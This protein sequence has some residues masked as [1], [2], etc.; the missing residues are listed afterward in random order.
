[1]INPLRTGLENTRVWVY[2]ARI[3][4]SPKS[5]LNGLT[6]R[7]R[8]TL[9]PIDVI[10]GTAGSRSEWINHCIQLPYSLDMQLVG[11]SS[12]LFRKRASIIRTIYF[13]VQTF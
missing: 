2:G 12:P 9:F 5:I 11:W 4:V 3:R 1:M 7:Q 6:L 13:E 10:H 8:Y